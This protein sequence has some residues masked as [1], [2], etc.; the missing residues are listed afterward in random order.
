MHE[1]SLMTDLM[2]KID[3]AAQRQQAR[4]ILGVAV[5]LGA[6]SHMSADHF[7][8]HFVQ[9]SAGTIADGAALDITVSDDIHNA[10]ASDIRLESLKVEV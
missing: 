2:H 4:R 5:W 8:E 10:H 1:A 6:L 9:A 7:R 3:D